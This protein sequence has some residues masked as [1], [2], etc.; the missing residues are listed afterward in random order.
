MAETNGITGY[1]VL[2]EAEVTVINEVKQIAICVG[3]VCDQVS[4]IGGVDH[5]WLNIARTDLQKGFMALVR[6]IAKPETF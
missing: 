4:T 6:S 1:H 5:R 3:E 2:S